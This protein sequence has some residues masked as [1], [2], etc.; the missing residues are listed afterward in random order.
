MRR[1]TNERLVNKS[2]CV[3]CGRQGRS[4]RN[5]QSRDRVAAKSRSSWNNVEEP[6][7]GTPAV[8]ITAIR[9]ETIDVY[10]YMLPRFIAFPRSL[11]GRRSSSFKQRTKKNG[12]KSLRRQLSLLPCIVY[13][14][15]F[16][17]RAD[18]FP[19]CTWKSAEWHKTRK[20]SHR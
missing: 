16:T 15:E 10:E 19:S 5:A 17:E 9:T 3:N 2:E 13:S 4:V 7:N 14:P 1:C 18:M 20:P 12:L 6:C 8:T 11:Y